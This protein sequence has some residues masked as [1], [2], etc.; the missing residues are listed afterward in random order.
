MRS[1]RLFFG[2]VALA[3]VTGCSGPAAG[4]MT[5]SAQNR[6]STG[7]Q[8]EHGPGAGAELPPEEDPVER[9]RVAIPPGAPQRGPDDALVTIVVFSDLQCPFC[10]RLVPTLDTLEETYGARLRIVW[11][12][13][14]LPF[15]DRAEPAAAA[16]REALAQQGPRGFWRMHDVL[17]E[18]QRDLEREDL[19]RYAAQLGLDPARFASALDSDRHMAAIDVDAADAARMGVRGT[20]TVFVNGRMIRG[21]QPLEAFV[22][23]VNDELRRGDALVA[24]GVAPSQL[25]A[26][27][28]RSARE[29]VSDEE[30]SLA[31]AAPG[32]RPEPDPA[33][34]YRVP[35]DGAP[36]LGAAGSGS[37][38]RPG[39]ARASVSSCSSGTCS[40]ALRIRSA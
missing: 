4:S 20:P 3:L 38:R 19:A 17:F 21:A 32:R 37:G 11:R 6:A 12:D 30:D 10:A 31:R 15:H 18:N 7:A 24:R 26:L 14:P 2:A 5:G 40:R 34:V 25:Y 39:A 28:M 27:R 23:I 9:V 33:A 16:A 8:A 35:V 36:V 22:A 1:T 13:L 29:Q